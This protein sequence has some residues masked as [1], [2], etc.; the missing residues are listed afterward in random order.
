MRK[1]EYKVSESNSSK[2]NNNGRTEMTPEERRQRA[3]EQAEMHTYSYDERCT[4]CGS[5]K[6]PK[7]DK[8]C[9]VCGAPEDTPAEGRKGPKYRCGGQYTQKPQIQNHTDKWWGL[10]P[11]QKERVRVKH[12]VQCLYCDERRLE[13]TGSSTSFGWDCK[14]CGERN[15]PI[16]ETHDALIKAEKALYLLKLEAV[17][18]E[19]MVMT[20][21][22]IDRIGYALTGLR[23]AIREERKAIR[24]N[25]SEGKKVR[26]K[27]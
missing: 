25:P 20:P 27:A 5:G 2:D 22:T 4:P 17:K 21:A 3:I 6:L 13:G 8:A 16:T 11:A 24:S 12:G 18:D 15:E 26:S 10:C 1:E 19:P 14:A 7:W 23:K 9:P